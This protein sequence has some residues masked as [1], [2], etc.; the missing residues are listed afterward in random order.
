M[1]RQTIDFILA[2]SERLRIAKKDLDYDK[3]YITSTMLN[4]IYNILIN[5]GYHKEH[6]DKFFFNDDYPNI[7][8]KLTEKAYKFYHTNRENSS[9]I[10]EKFFNEDPA[11]IKLRMEI[12][13]LSKK[14]EF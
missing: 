7:H 8:K 2:F 14:G 1:T 4:G 12:D 6:L 9:K 3:E 13:K 5:E 10:I 11:G